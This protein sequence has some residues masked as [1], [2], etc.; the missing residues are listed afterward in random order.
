MSSNATQFKPTYFQIFDKSTTNNCDR[1]I[2]V[3]PFDWIIW[4]KFGK[5]YVLN[6]SS[7]SCP[8]GFL[9]AVAV[10]STKTDDSGY[11]F[12][13]VCLNVLITDIIAAYKDVSPYIEYFEIESL[14][15]QEN[16]FT[17]LDALNYLLTKYITMKSDD[18]L[19][20][21]KQDT[22]IVSGIINSGK[23][24]KEKIRVKRE[25]INPHFVKRTPKNLSRA[26]L[27]TIYK[28]ANNIKN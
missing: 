22:V 1:L 21:I 18:E 27:E 28:L 4:A 13:S 19:L 20:N 5:I 6:Q 14:Q 15:S 16:K 3:Q 11:D 9:A 25:L 2:R 12:K 17:V 23:E 7:Y 26:K 8:V 24:V 10:P